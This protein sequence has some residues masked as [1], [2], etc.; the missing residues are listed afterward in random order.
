[1]FI[2]PCK[3]KQDNPVIYRCIE[4]INKFSPTSTILLVDSDS[5]DK[6]YLARCK[7]YKNVCVS[8]IKN[9][10]YVE[11][12]LWHAYSSFRSEKWYF[13]IHDSVYLTQCLDEYFNR[14]FVCAY[15]FKDYAYLDVQCWSD[16]NDMYRVKWAYEELLHT[17]YFDFIQGDI[18]GV[19]GSI[20]LASR[21]TLDFLKS[22]NVD[23]II[24]KN[25]KELEAMERVWGMIF[26]QMGFSLE[27]NSI[28]GFLKNGEFPFYG[29]IRKSF[30]NR[31]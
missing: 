11:G 2:I 15:Y 31:K 23:S 30:L 9:N 24:P 29:K 14:D 10:G 17:N 20:F 22:K 28:D 1:M 4:S 3:F 25:K 18:Y 26:L 6:S 8:D 27:E 7:T 5:D 16:S 21:N 19:L 13:I 12:A